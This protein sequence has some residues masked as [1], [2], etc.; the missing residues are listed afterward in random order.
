MEA[1]TWRS[2]EQQLGSESWDNHGGLYSMPVSAATTEHV[3]DHMD[4]FYPHHHHQHL[5]G[6]HGTASTMQQFPSGFHGHFTAM[7]PQFA[8]TLHSNSVA[9]R[10]ERERNR[11]RFIN[12][13]FSRLRQHLPCSEKKKLSKVDTLRT[14][15][16]YIKH[17]QHIL[18]VQDQEES[19]TG[20][21][22]TV[23]MADTSDEEE[24][25]SVADEDS[26]CSSFDWTRKQCDISSSRAAK[27]SGSVTSG[28]DCSL[29]LDIEDD[30]DSER[31]SPDHNLGDDWL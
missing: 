19:K 16:R 11:V 9:R 8:Y 14:A 28:T 10:N 2:W 23:K 21:D 4:H 12:K 29:D 27:S 30:L 7:S 17:L 13:T 3:T 15:I 22:V 18:D 20:S 6:F 26:S 31:H 24:K 1:P 25:R 5:D